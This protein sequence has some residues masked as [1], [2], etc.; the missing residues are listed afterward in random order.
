M[1]SPDK[2]GVTRHSHYAPAS[3][4]SGSMQSRNT[5]S[6][7]AGCAMGVFRSQSP[8]ALL[9]CCLMKNHVPAV[10]F[11]QFE[12]FSPYPVVNVNGKRGRKNFFLS[13]LRLLVYIPNRDLMERNILVFADRVKSAIVITFLPVP[14]PLGTILFEFMSH[15]L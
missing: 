13:R 4:A 12:S 10:S 9:V 11:K 3:G 2:T 14:C 7:T 15:R 1:R 8:R 5:Q 6:I